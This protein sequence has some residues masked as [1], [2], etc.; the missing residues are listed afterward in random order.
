MSSLLQGLWRDLCRCRPIQGYSSFEIFYSSKSFTHLLNV[1]GNFTASKLKWI[2]DHEPELIDKIYKAMLPGDYINFKL[3]GEIN[4]TSSALSEGTLWD[5]KNQ[6]VANFLLKEIGISEEVIPEVKDT[7]SVYGTVNEV[8]AKQLGIPC[9]TPV[10][11]RAGDQPNNA[12]S[13]GVNEPGEVAATGGTSGVVYALKDSLVYDE[14]TRVNSF[15]HVNHTNND[16][17]IG[18]LLCINGAGSMYRWINQTIAPSNISYD[19]MEEEIIRKV[20]KSYLDSKSPKTE[21]NQLEFVNKKCRK[22]G[23][24]LS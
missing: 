8:V 20:M 9:G 6:T 3:T 19:K 4:T 12:M 24:P 1:P 21:E 13:L 5:F 17:K 10:C 2:A 11:Y 14:H 15:A 7:F 18:V 23:R 16:S 22:V